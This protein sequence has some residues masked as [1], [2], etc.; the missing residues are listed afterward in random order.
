MYKLKFWT[1]VLNKL[2]KSEQKY[3]VKVMS[4]SHIFFG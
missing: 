3:I 2:N 1:N 4:F